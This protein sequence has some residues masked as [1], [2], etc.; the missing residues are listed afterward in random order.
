MQPSST[1][2]SP[3]LKRCLISE[4]VRK[5]HVMIYFR[6]LPTIFQYFALIFTM[7]EAPIQI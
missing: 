7:Q 6:G 3:K 5:W 2:S 4:A 1:S